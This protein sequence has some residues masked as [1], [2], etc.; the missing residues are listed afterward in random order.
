MLQ[1][2]LGLLHCSPTLLLPAV[3]TGSLCRLL[4]MDADISGSHFPSFEMV[5]VLHPI[6]IMAELKEGHCLV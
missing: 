3:E 2:Q 1:V 4:S 5:C 6:R